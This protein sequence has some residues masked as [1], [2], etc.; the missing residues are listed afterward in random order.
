MIGDYPR[1]VYAPGVRWWR[2]GGT[3][4]PA[5]SAQ[6]PQLLAWKHGSPL[7]EIVVDEQSSLSLSAMYRAVSL[8]AGLLGA[9][10]LNSW[11]ATDAG[12]ERVSS[13]F[14]QPDGPDDLTPFEWKEHLI[15]HLVLHGDGYALKLR[16]DAGGLA[17]MPLLHPLTV[18]K[19]KPTAE[20]VRRGTV[21]KGG[22]WFWTALADGRYVR[23][24][25][26]DVWHVPGPAGGGLIER[27]R[28]SVGASLAGDRA[29]QR[30]FTHGAMISGLA[31]PEDDDVGD[32]IDDVP[33]IRRQIDDAV[34]GPDR[35][36][37][38]AV[39]ARRL[40]FT[41]WTMT[42]AD[43]QFLQQRQFQIE[44]ISRWTGVPPHALMQTE[45]QTS[46]GTGVES[47][48]RGMARTV[49]NT[50]ATRIEQRGSRLLQQPRWIEFDF[51]KLERPSPDVERDMIRSDWNDGLVT[52]NEARARMGLAPLPDGDVLKGAAAPEGGPDADPTAE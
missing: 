23:L 17:R 45:K 7:G 24:D 37:G 48:D 44:E 26:D 36:G 32:I 49:L 33:E 20:Q 46:W 12:R 51:S 34:A 28:A 40:K 52:L 22:T 18:T 14:D 38:I 42:A 6:L 9:S 15:T 35:A 11:R 43:A 25:G 29:A 31:T 50:W 39:L 16:N 47:Q 21:P 41:P 10:P 8:I 5:N 3:G 19:Q 2:R 27:A 1:G 30:M 4:R 13:I